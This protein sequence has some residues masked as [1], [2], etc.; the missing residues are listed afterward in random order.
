MAGCPKAP[1]SAWEERN[2]LVKQRKE[3]VPEGGNP[4]KFGRPGSGRR[5]VNSSSN[6]QQSSAQIAK[7]HKVVYEVDTTSAVGTII[8]HFLMANEELRK[9]CNAKDDV[10]RLARDAALAAD[11][12]FGDFVLQSNN[13]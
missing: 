1:P 5:L 11:T 9:S 6:K 8:G 3:F 13:K 2:D 7:N 12:A 4:R 10:L